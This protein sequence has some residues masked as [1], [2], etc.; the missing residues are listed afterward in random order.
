M[1][2]LVIALATAG[3]VGFAPVASGTF[4][5]LVAIP[6]VVALASLRQ[7]SALWH[8]VAVAAVVAV[9]IWSAGRAEEVFGGHDHSYI[10]ID[11]VAGMLIACCGNPR[12]WPWV[13]G[14][15]L[16]FRAFDVLKPLG[17]NRLQSLPGGFGVV[18]D[19]LLAG[20]YASLLGQLRHLV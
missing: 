8:T 3:G 12:T 15:F 9:A 7:R 11:E 18:V 14:L 2:L 20:V 10:V 19:D 1:R 16:A 4:G 5:T 17:I 13:L 6:L